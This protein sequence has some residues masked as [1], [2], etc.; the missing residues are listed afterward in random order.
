[1]QRFLVERGII[2]VSRVGCKARGI[3]FLPFRVRVAL[4]RLT[5]SVAR[6]RGRR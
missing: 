2:P 3:S 1:M 4:H 6:C 5:D